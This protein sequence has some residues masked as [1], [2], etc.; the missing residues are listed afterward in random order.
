MS[1]NYSILKK[2][3]DVMEK[4][5]EWSG[6]KV[7]PTFRSIAEDL[8]GQLKAIRAKYKDTTGEP[9]KLWPTSSYD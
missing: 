7:H 9:V 4:L 8:V 1:A 6:Y 3:P 2:D 5:L